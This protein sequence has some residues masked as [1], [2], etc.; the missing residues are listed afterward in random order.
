[1][2][3]VDALLVAWK[4]DYHAQAVKARLG[5][6]GKTAVILDAADFPIHSSLTCQFDDNGP[7]LV[8]VDRFDGPL[9]VGANTGIWWRRPAKHDVADVFFHP[10]L[11]SFAESEARHALLGALRAVSSH[12]LN[13][14]ERSTA[15]ALKPFQLA[16]ALKAGLRIPKTAITNRQEDV[17]AQEKIWGPLVYKTLGGTD[18]GFFE[19]RKFDAAEDGHDLRMLS[20]CPTIFQEYVEGDYDVR[21]TVVGRKCFPAKVDFMSGQ[22]PVDSRIDPKN[23]I[24]FEL[25]KEIERSI[26]I[27]MDLAGLN[28]A[29]IDMR[30]SERKGFTFF[31]LNPEGQYLWIE[32]HT[33]HAISK[34]IAAFLAGPPELRNTNDLP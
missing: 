13:L 20:T 26:F 15:A 33:G 3:N 16:L 10:K 4:Q 21:V 19:T 27:L 2:K 32:R 30:F 28:Y 24:A 25:P 17:L 34:A 5:D 6:L 31:E 11:K 23:F 18:F 7:Q 8:F 14:P 9:K 1:M 29:A 22:H 12:F